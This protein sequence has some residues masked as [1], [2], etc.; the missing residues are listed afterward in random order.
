MS[1]FSFYF[2]GSLFTLK[3]INSVKNDIFVIF[4][5]LLLFAMFLVLHGIYK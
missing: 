1:A 2:N 3:D 4:L 5:I